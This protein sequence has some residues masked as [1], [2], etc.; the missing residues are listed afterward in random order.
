MHRSHTQPIGFSPPSIPPSPCLAG[1][2]QS[3]ARFPPLP[4]AEL[5]GWGALAEHTDLPSKIA[6]LIIGRDLISDLC[7]VRAL[8]C[9]NDI[10]KANP[11]FAQMLFLQGKP[12][13]P[14]GCGTELGRSP[15]QTGGCT[16]GKLK[17]SLFHILHCQS[18]HYFVFKYF[19]K[20]G[21]LHFLHYF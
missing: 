10:N 6:G 7:Q 19:P 5:Q 12:P 14:R 20:I 18:F 16:P 1:N 8:G 9:V 11:A 13:D 4:P 3:Q 17:C 2:R 21:V 15:G